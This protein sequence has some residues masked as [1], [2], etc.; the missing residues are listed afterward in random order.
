MIIGLAS[1]N[2]IHEISENLNQKTVELTS[3]RLG[4]EF[5]HMVPWM[6]L[7]CLTD[8]KVH[9]LSIFLTQ[10]RKGDLIVSPEHLKII[11]NFLKTEGKP[12][13][14]S[15]L[16]PLS[17]LDSSHWFSVIEDLG[18]NEKNWTD[19]YSK[20]R[21]LV[22]AS[23]EFFSEIFTDLVHFVVPIEAFGKFAFSTHLARGAVFFS[24]PEPPHQE[25][26]MAVDLVHEM[27]HQAM[28]LFQSAS[29]LLTSPLDQPLWSAIRKTY[30]P[31]IQ[32][33]QA[34]SALAYMVVFMRGAMKN[35]NLNA[36]EK[37]FLQESY[38]KVMDGLA[39]TL[40]GLVENSKFT[41]LGNQ[42]IKE[43]GQL[44]NP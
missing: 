29:P 31:A 42:I 40:D 36:E 9:D 13:V 35:A 14:D 21:S 33:L 2:A 37:E 22:V 18:A 41:P 20:A 24:A 7:V 44:L 8:T 25:L 32:C 3:Q 38:D 1:A 15:S 4:H 26:R 19:C 30:R 23:D 6:C 12:L 16:G 5:S 10:Y 39:K 34:A 17:G 43:F 11:G 28:M 27:G